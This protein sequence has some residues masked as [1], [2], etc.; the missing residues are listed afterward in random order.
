MTQFQPSAEV[1]YVKEYDARDC[2]HAA[3]SVHQRG[4]IL[5]FVCNIFVA[6]IKQ[7][8]IIEPVIGY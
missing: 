5:V 1:K 6:C 4:C 3:Y 8:T 7:Y 2:R